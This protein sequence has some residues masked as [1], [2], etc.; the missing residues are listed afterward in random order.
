MENPSNSTGVQKLHPHQD[1]PILTAI[2]FFLVEKGR[3]DRF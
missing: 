1:S 3:G 2:A